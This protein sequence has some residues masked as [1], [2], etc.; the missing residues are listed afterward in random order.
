MTV[1]E[2]IRLENPSLGLIPDDEL[3]E[4]LLLEYQGDLDPE[5]YR[6]S[7]MA[8]EPAVVSP[9]ESP[10]AGRRPIGVGSSPQDIGYGEAFTSG[11]KSM[12][13]RTWGP[14]VNYL[15]GGIAGLFGDEENAQRLYQEAREQD[16]E[17]L[18]RTGYVTFEQATKGPDAGIDTFVKFGLQ[19]AGMSLPYTLFGGVGGIAG[20]ALLGQT[21]GKTAAT[22]TGATATFLPTTAQFN[23]ARQVEEVERGNLDEVNE[24]AAFGAALPSAI[25]ESALYPVLG[26]LFGPLSRT[27][28]SNVISRATLGRVAKGSATGAV[29]EA[30]TE[31][32]QQAIE[33]YQAGLP[34]DS[35]DALN[36][37]KEAAAGAAF[38]GGLF[39]GATTTAGE[40]ARTVQPTPT[41][42]PVTQPTAK[43]VE[44]PTVKAGIVQPQQQKDRAKEEAAKEQAKPA[45]FAV[46]QEGD[47]FVVKSQELDANN[48]VIKT[49]N[50]GV[51]NTEAEAT[52]KQQEIQDQKNK[53]PE[54]T[55][56]T[57]DEIKTQDPTLGSIIDEVESQ[58][59]KISPGTKQ[60]YY[61]KDLALPQGDLT[62]VMN[63]GGTAGS[64]A[65]GW[66]DRTSDLAYI[67]LS[68]L[69]KAKETVAHENFHALQRVTD[70][71]SPNLFTEQEQ[72]ALDNLLP[73]GTIDSITPNVQKALGND[74]MN[75][76]RE[77]HADRNISN[78][79]MQAYAFG[80][81]ATLRNNNKLL[82]APNPVI[83]AFRKL[84]DFI[85]RAGNIFR[86]NKINDV[87]DIFDKA[88]LGDIGKRAKTQPDVDALRTKSLAQAEKA[89]AKG[90]VPTK[91][92][93]SI[94]TKKYRGRD[95]GTVL[96]TLD[97]V[98]G[99]D[100]FEKIYNQAARKPQL[101]QEYIKQV[102]PEQRTAM[103]AVID[104]GYQEKELID[105][106]GFLIL[107]DDDGKTYRIGVQTG[108]RN[109]SRDYTNQER[110]QIA[111]T[112]KDAMA[113]Q[114]TRKAPTEF[115]LS[116]VKFRK[117]PPKISEKTTVLQI[118]K[119]FDKKRGKPL[120]YN[121]KK[122][123]NTGVKNAVKEINY[124]LDPKNLLD[125]GLSWYDERYQNALKNVQEV[126]PEVKDPA[127]RDIFTAIIAIT[128]PNNKVYRNFID[129]TS[130]ANEYAKTG[131]IP[132]VNPDT[133][134]LIGGIVGQN[135]KTNLSLANQLLQQRGVEGFRDFIFGESTYDQLV[136]IKRKSGLYKT[137]A[138]EI[139]GQTKTIRNKDTGKVEENILNNTAIFGPKVNN[140]FLNLT[141][142]DI[143]AT[144]DVW[145][146]RF[147]YR[148]F[149]DTLLDASD[150]DGI[151]KAPKNP[152]DRAAMQRFMD[153]VR[154]E[155][156]LT[157]RD[158]QAVAWYYEQ[159]LYTD[160]GVKSIP[161]DFEK[162]STRVVKEIKEGKYGEARTEPIRQV[163]Q[164]ETR[165]GEAE[166]ETELSTS[167]QKQ[168]VKE[169]L[170][171]SAS[172][173][174]AVKDFDPNAFKKS[175]SD[176]T[177]FEPQEY[178]SA[179]DTRGPLFGHCAAC[180]YVIQKYFGGKVRELVVAP[181][182]GYNTKRETHYFN[183]LD[184]GTFI[185]VTGE[186]YG[187]KGVTPP[188]EFIDK[189]KKST[190][191]W[192]L[193]DPKK[194]KEEN[195]RDAGVQALNPRFKKFEEK[196]LSH[197]NK[198]KLI[199]P[200]LSV[201]NRVGAYA[202]PIKVSQQ[203]PTKLRKQ[204]KE[205][206]GMT[207]KQFKRY[208]RKDRQLSNIAESAINNLEESYEFRSDSD[209]SEMLGMVVANGYVHKSGVDE[210]GKRNFFFATDDKDNILAAQQFKINS[211][212]DNTKAFEKAH[213]I[214]VSY[215]SARR[216]V[217]K[218]YSKE[219]KLRMDARKNPDGYDPD[220]VT[221]FTDKI[222]DLYQNNSQKFF[223]NQNPK[224]NK[225]ALEID[226][227]ASFN[228]KASEALMQEA[229]N[230]AKSKNL[231]T[232]VLTDIKSDR[233]ISAFA[234]RGFKEAKLG[235]IYFGGTKRVGFAGRDTGVPKTNMVAEVSALEAKQKET[236]QNLDELTPELS[237]SKDKRLLNPPGTKVTVDLARD[238]E[239][240][241]NFGI[242]PTDN[243]SE[244]IELLAD[245]L[246]SRG[247]EDY[248]DLQVIEDTGLPIFVA[249]IK[250][251]DVPVGF[252]QGAITGKIGFIDYVGLYREG[253]EYLSPIGFRRVGKQLAKLLGVKQFA[254]LRVTGAR[255]EVQRRTDRLLDQ[256]AISAEF[257]VSNVESFYKDPMNYS[258]YSLS[259][260]TPQTDNFFTEAK[261]SS[262]TDNRVGKIPSNVGEL[263]FEN[264][265][266]KEGTPVAVRLNLNT[267]I[268]HDEDTGK[269]KKLKN[270]FANIKNEEGYKLSKEKIKYRNK[271][272]KEIAIETG[273][274]IGTLQTAHDK[275]TDGDALGYDKAIIV[276]DPTFDVNQ[277][278]RFQVVEKGEKTPMASVKGGIV[279]KK[280]DKPI[281]GKRLFFNPFKHHLF[282]DGSDNAV[283]SVKGEV[284]V[285][286]SAAYTNDEI[287][288]Y[289]REQGEKLEIA[290]KDNDSQV[291]YKYETEAEKKADQPLET[292]TLSKE[293]LRKFNLEFSASTRKFSDGTQR[294]LNTINP[295][296]SR[297]T[298][299]AHWKDF[300][301]N[302]GVKFQQGLSDQY[303]SVK[304]FVGEEEYKS[305]TMTY[306][307]SGA[308]EAALLYGVPFM[309]NMGAIDLKD[310]TI[311]TGLF[312]R[313]E[314]LGQ[315]LPDF[316]AW[317]AANRARNLVNKGF[318]SGL[319]NIND[320]NTAIKE[321][322]QGKEKQFNESLKDLQEFNKAF[323]DIGV[324]S[325]YIDPASAKVWTE[326][327]G[328]NFYIPFYRLLEDRDSNS[329]PRAAAD[330]VNQPDYPR[331]R[332]ADLPV[333]DLLQNIIRNYSFLTEASL[334]NA[335]GLKTLRKAA[336]MGVA[337][338]VPNKTKTSVFVR[339]KGKMEHYEVENKLVLESL[340]ALNWNGWQN[341]AM[342][343]M[344]NFK[345][346]LT[347]G[348]TFS[349]AFRI[350]NLLRD[351]I[352][353]VAVG[354]LKYN[355][356]ANVLE[357]IQG[358]KKN[359][360]LGASELRARMA[361][362]GGSIHFGH[363]Y[364]DDPNATKMLLDRAIDVNTVM[365]RD[366][367]S[368]GA[369]RVLNSKLKNSLKWWEETGSFF[370]NVNRAALYQQLRAKGISHFEAAYQARDL[371][372]FSRHG[373]NPFVRFL[374]QSIP[375]LNARI[376][377]L[378]KL[379]RAMTKE[380]R[381]QLVTVL[382]TYSLASIGL[383]LAY[384]DDE[385]FKEREQW[386]R[387]TYHWFKLPNDAGVF[388][389]PRPFEVGAVGVIFERMV[390][391]MVDDDV[392]GQLL[393]ER[394]LHTIT[395]TFAV[396]IRPQLITPAL[397]VYS[398]KD[399][400]TDRPIESLGMRRLPASERKYAY[401]SSAYVGASKILELIPF[402]KVQFSPVQIE[403]LVQGY[404]GWV[405]S[406][407]VSA[408]SIVDYP[409]KYSEFFTT[410][411][412][413]PLAMGFFKGLPSLQSKYKTQFYD[414]R[415]KMEEVS[416]LM[417]LYERRGEY[418]KAL[419][420]A[421]K[422]K[423]LLQWRG[424]YNKINT[425]I[426][427]INREIRR[428]QADKNL[429]ET[430]KL[431]R[432]RQLSIIKNDMIQNLTESVLSWEK[433]TGQK[434]KRPLWWK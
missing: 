148:H 139:S 90:V 419:E 232:I 377:G 274:S 100:I 348:V 135:T 316:L 214:I 202:G 325:G 38:V 124:Q 117:K 13:Q 69:G 306:G 94:T 185:D 59:A 172:A 12:W 14:G 266:L 344:R 158:A 64:V 381:A 239:T 415:R 390:E 396:D 310:K 49:D 17:I 410:G 58:G 19:Q 292:D 293:Q 27:Q 188:K 6:Q 332:G 309:D 339:D 334:K 323:L 102:R 62:N 68:D 39:G 212:P 401:T 289:S 114:Q 48:N 252:I 30:I 423:N 108:G 399:S 268:F 341:P 84:F 183:E 162:A 206:I 61:R 11:L 22:M 16:Q 386:D 145:F 20:R 198:P 52:A 134:N 210:E 250:V 257:S 131:Q 355:P 405:G 126:L 55:F 248:G 143:K 338:R 191:N 261:V 82:S 234:R 8:E 223:R 311:G 81:Y 127:F 376:Q 149:T 406:A 264:R 321:L 409:R 370:E 299:A 418:K 2:Q 417:R 358:L 147:F 335:A 267:T 329:G 336:E 371:L 111:R 388:R 397:E 352:H 229:I 269:I 177:A 281:E 28:F 93:Y 168:R 271:R 125:T 228:M 1:L 41:D 182:E 245:K 132:N 303:I 351:S 54:Q 53:L 89:A 151:K 137:G 302:W 199:E 353:S 230:F 357:G 180:V 393:A 373:A 40:I 235:S 330:I 243:V 322:Q 400:F 260:N 434:L 154:D 320:I 237:V 213:N 259:D 319:G 413:S 218:E 431:D 174:T 427:Q 175:G 120:D 60:V 317:V 189:S 95:V 369:R 291:L 425:K 216:K 164:I 432:T 98:Y 290:T 73:G 238:L 383:Y 159:G 186:Q 79:E 297:K 47:K 129:S 128:S 272:K 165:E 284:T 275:N 224:Y 42:A 166:K 67:S 152:S 294:V 286:N 363:I 360:Q 313:F 270:K 171:F 208:D 328:Y 18:N 403:H 26:K 178:L 169:E 35:P 205:Q 130:V 195:K 367:W 384:K 187:N 278:K 280:I 362:G 167:G 300:T 33:R 201:T 85:K 66:Y 276:K 287:E 3:I 170:E 408:V 190:K 5:I 217:L 262:E 221:E 109:A 106:N 161:L 88:R 395:E 326:D 15:K 392:H 324:K 331:F 333:N 207:P 87:K 368:A 412:D 285:F 51:F 32:G 346:Y 80:A 123:F 136:E 282:V 91:F 196:Y 342:N 203:I 97:N 71:V 78:R 103:S 179:V 204:I 144:E 157:K 140:F 279:Q 242:E 398:N 356:M 23:I 380:Q 101:K 361:F 86:K 347:Y 404:F 25:L 181:I 422:N 349:P 211:F 116:T 92:E 378:D 192:G 244:E 433:S 429:T 345:R 350:R 119:F 96:P 366:G 107:S 414:M 354:K 426:T 209:R 141:G 265:K 83:R 236:T 295:K 428:I 4:K 193:F 273:V 318:E 56:F 277:K 24:A 256:S 304:K 173:S 146:S 57:A 288:Y 301:D 327:N 337:R 104:F 10:T 50:Q 421:E 31:V 118:A 247:I 253:Q 219:E 365:E 155:T 430:E 75:T 138:G 150:K 359:K 7:L 115:A 263:L 315:D 121:V 200:E 9:V 391:Q 231:D 99:T 420:L 314:R 44:T 305:L 21:I 296:Q 45:S 308:T 375:F 233:S 113:I 77:R 74:V 43:P 70:R 163:P 76:L 36:E 374:T 240:L 194:S 142:S 385:D 65:D 411:F 407:V 258:E 382:G 153:A 379:G 387:D 312:T 133:G 227:G 112:F 110:T 424:A 215:D 241:E 220:L 246:F 34:I 254:G 29:T 197:V 226:V 72:T 251:D 122:D 225:N 343:I 298:V 307:S 364:G 46:Q 340:T 255:K 184:D 37:Y 156:G 283:K 389:I 402:E 160:L 372:N 249:G 105:D 222:T 63:S 176:V 394:I 416:N